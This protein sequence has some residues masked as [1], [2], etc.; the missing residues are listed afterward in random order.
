[1]LSVP[2]PA[3]ATWA[4]VG[5]DGIGKAASIVKITDEESQVPC[6]AFTLYVPAEVIPLIVP[7]PNTLAPATAASVAVV[8]V[9]VV[10]AG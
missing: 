1:M 6:F 4:T 5:V 10:P 2:Q 3:A 7:S 9:K 8:M